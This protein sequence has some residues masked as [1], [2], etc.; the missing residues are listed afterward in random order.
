MKTKTII[1][2][3]LLLVVGLLSGCSASDREPNY[4]Y[5]DYG[6]TNTDPVSP[7]PVVQEPDVAG[8]DVLQSAVIPALENRKII[9]TADLSMTS[10]EP[11]DVYNNIINNLDTYSAYIESA[12]ITSSRYIVK[13][14]V[15]SVNFTDFVEEI[16]TTGDIVSFNKSSDD[17]T[18]S[19]STFEA[20]KLAL[21][22]QHTRILELIAA[23]IDLQDILTL[24]DARFE[25]E[26]ELNEI[27]AK[28]ANFDSLVDF[29]TINLVIN[30]ATET[31]VVLPAT[32][33]PSVSV[34]E[35]EKTT[36]QLEVYNSSA[37]PVVIYVDVLQNGEFIKQ[38]EK[39]AYGESTVL[40]NIDKLKSFKDYTF[41][42]ST[43]AADHRESSVISREVLTE[44]TFLNRVTN[45]FVISFNTLVSLVQFVGLAVVAVSPYLVL[46]A[47]SFYPVKFLHSIYRKKFPK[48]ERVLREYPARKG[49]AIKS[50]NEET[51]E[52]QNKDAKYL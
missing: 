46:I 11:V 28:L 3:F 40:F 27:G 7:D 35:I 44:K 12:N 26:T 17:V 13:I 29:S 49:E 4:V 31:V 14:R 37:S 15:L 43:I 9:Y 16:K 23:A 52:H 18:N 8:G 21:E 38:Y 50:K 25:I 36:V 34:L 19:Y 30:K 42:V 48:K 20:R 24:E 39:D 10:E 1:F 2:T 47:V 6:T 22:T 51:K 5:D 32:S 41:K 33:N 45:V